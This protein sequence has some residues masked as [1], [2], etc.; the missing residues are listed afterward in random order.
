[1]EGVA[2]HVLEV[3]AQEEGLFLGEAVPEVVVHHNPKEVPADV[4]GDLAVGRHNLAAPADVVEDL[5]V[6]RHN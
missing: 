3:E 5:A 1:M 6:G 4:V 2:F